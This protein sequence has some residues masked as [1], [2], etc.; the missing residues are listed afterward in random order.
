MDN[1]GVPTYVSAVSAR[2]VG[3]PVTWFPVLHLDAFRVY[4]E[5]EAARMTVTY[6]TRTAE[7]SLQMALNAWL[8]SWM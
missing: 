7:C 3:K 2:L 6:P 5:Y 8:S 1:G 4:Q